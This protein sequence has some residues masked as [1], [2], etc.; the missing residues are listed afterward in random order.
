MPKVRRKNVPRGVVEHLARR[1]RERHVPVED[2]QSLAQW[3]DADPTVP[4]GAWFKRFAKIIVCGEGDLV[5][6]FLEEQHSA[7]GIE[8]E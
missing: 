6:T 4:N 7:V 1:V 2:L 3:L 8:V 5:K